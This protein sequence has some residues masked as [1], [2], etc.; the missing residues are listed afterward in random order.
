MNEVLQWI[1]I[2]GL[3][4]VVIVP[5]ATRVVRDFKEEDTDE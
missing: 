1:C 2:A 5:A 4:V 3:S